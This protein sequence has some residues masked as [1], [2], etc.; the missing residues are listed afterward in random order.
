MFSRWVVTNITSARISCG[1]QLVVCG[2]YN[3]NGGNYV[4]LASCEAARHRFV[5]SL[6]IH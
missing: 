1:D 2:L 6:T 5:L 3:I 4:V